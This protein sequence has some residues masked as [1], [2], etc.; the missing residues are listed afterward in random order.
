MAALKAPLLHLDEEAEADRNN[1]G[2]PRGLTMSN[3]S[4]HNERLGL[5]E[6]Q[7]QIV[8]KKDAVQSKKE[9]FGELETGDATRQQQQSSG[10]MSNQHVLMVTCASFFLFVIGEIIGAVAGH[11]WSLL[12]DAAAMSVDVCTYFTNMVAERIKAQSGGEPLSERTRLILEVAIPS[13]SVCALL[14]VTAYV[15]VGAV[16]DIITPPEGGDDVDISILYGFASANMLVDIISAYMF[17]RKGRDVFFANE[18]LPSQFRE[19]LHISHIS[20]TNDEGDRE[21]LD[22]SAGPEREKNLN[23][24]SPNPTRHF[25]LIFALNYTHIPDVNTHTHMNTH[26]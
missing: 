13:F 5:L 3:S 23:M 12:G 6:Q 14:G 1:S 11:S 22:L 2:S 16:Q 7:P 15:T 25:R 20:V 26:T 9:Q 24:V 8:A 10:G 21:P 17:Y 4:E 19:G 18:H